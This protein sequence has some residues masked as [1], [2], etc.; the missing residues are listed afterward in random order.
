M[1]RRRRTHPSWLSSTW[2]PAA[3]SHS[4]RVTCVEGRHVW[5]S[6][7]SRW[8]ISLG[9]RCC[10]GHIKPPW[11]LRE[12][13]SRP[14]RQPPACTWNAG[15]VNTRCLVIWCSRCTTVPSTAQCTPMRTR[16]PLRRLAV[17]GGRAG[18]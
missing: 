13:S 17:D 4:S 12:A 14:G 18:G 6:V 16:G 7:A 11:L 9:P 1:S 10:A 2:P 15:P 3:A 5:A 8:R